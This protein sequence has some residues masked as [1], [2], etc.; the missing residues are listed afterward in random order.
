MAKMDVSGDSLP[1]DEPLNLGEI[2]GIE[3]GSIDI[4]NGDAVE[5]ERFMNEHVLVRVHDSNDENAVQAIPLGVNGITQWVM[6]G[7]PQEIRRKYVEVL[8]RARQTTYKQSAPRVELTDSRP[9]PKTA[10]SYPFSVE[11]DTSKGMAWLRE[12]MAQKA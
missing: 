3:V 8:A 4:A 9:E 7:A 5:L 11:R 2:G 1:K 12:I 10:M 6:R